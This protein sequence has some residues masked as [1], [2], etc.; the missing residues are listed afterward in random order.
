[1]SSQKRNNKITPNTR[2]ANSQIALSDLR[3]DEN[4]NYT[5]SFLYYDN[6]I[7]DLE[8]MSQASDLKKVFRF[9]MSV[10]HVCKHNEIKDCVPMEI[11]PIDNGDDYSKFWNGLSKDAEILEVDTGKHRCMFFTEEI[12]KVVYIRAVVKHPEDKKRKR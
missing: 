9:I 2:Y 8:S 11:K 6:K 10:C 12:A 1:M 7:S 4:K 3:L 5:V